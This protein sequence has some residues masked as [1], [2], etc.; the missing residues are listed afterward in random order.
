[1]FHAIH[2]CD[3]LSYF[4]PKARAKSYCRFDGVTWDR[5]LNS[6]TQYINRIQRPEWLSNSNGPDSSAWRR[7]RSVIRSGFVDR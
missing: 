1:M 7:N 3:H 2:L 4:D 6:K 5:W